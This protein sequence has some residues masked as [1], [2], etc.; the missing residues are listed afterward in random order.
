VKKILLISILLATIAIPTR[1]AS[2]PNPRV[3]LKKAL[4]YT[5]L[6]NVVYWLLLLLVYPRLD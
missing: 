5:A 6:F 3:A 2:E 4:L 1:A